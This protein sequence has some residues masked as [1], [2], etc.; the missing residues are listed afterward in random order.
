[1]GPLNLI[2]EL[3]PFLGQ[4]RVPRE[5]ELVMFAVWLYEVLVA[6]MLGCMRF[7]GVWSRHPELPRGTGFV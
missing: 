2:H 1:M 3:P 7:P 4:F 6:V 5:K